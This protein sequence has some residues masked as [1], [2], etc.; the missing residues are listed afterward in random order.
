VAYRAALDRLSAAGILRAHGEP[1][2]RFA[3]RVEKVA[4]SFGPL[5]AKHVGVAFGSRD[6]LRSIAT[7]EGKSLA[8]L[9]SRVGSEVRKRVPFWRWLIGLLNPVSWLWSR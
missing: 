4:P 7:V 2:E 8:E 3:K 6:A 9:S 5:T 1:R